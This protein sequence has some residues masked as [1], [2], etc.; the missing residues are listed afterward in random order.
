[1]SGEQQSNVKYEEEFIQS[2]G[3][4]KLFT[5]RWV[6]AERQSKAIICLCHGYGAE[7]SISM[8]DTAVRLT[9]AGYTVVGIDYEGHGK[10]DGTRCYIKNFDDLVADSAAFFRGV[11]ERVEYREKARFLYGESMGGAVAFLIHRK[12]PNFWSGAVLV[13]PML[14]IS[15]EC[16]PHPVVLSILRPL[17]AIIPTWKLMPTQD[18]SEVGIKDPEK[19]RELR[20]NPYIYQG[21]L[22][23]K[24]AF[25]LLRTSLDIEKRMDELMLPFLILHGEDDKITDP[26]A[27]KLVYASAKS[28]DKT[29][30]LYPD[31]W[32]GLAYGEPPEHTELVFSDMIGWLDERSATGCP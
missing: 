4:V 24:T 18:I 2:S 22:R 29:L 19:R 20:E 25:Q 30:K 8:K 6:P 12:Q 9:K 13:C 32:H 27:S 31:M 14:K 16:K 5:C 15:E 21:R 1:M 17:T 28:T 10:S 26:S 3:G 11:A 23:L 7:C